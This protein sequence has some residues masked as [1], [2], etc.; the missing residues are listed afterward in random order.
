MYSTIYHLTLRGWPE[1]RQEVPHIARHFWGGREELSIDSSLLLK[2]IRVC[3]PLEL[4]NC[5][6]ADLYGAHQGTNRMQTQAREAVYWPGIDADIADYV[7]TKC[8]K[9]KASPPA[10]PMLPRDVPDGPWQEIV[11][12][13]FTHKGKEYLLICDL[14]SKYPFMYMVSTI[15]AQSLCAHLL[16]LVSQYGP[17]SLLFTDN[18]QPFASEE[19]TQFLQCHHTDHSTLSPHFPRSNGFID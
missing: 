12:D 7:C 16:D 8:T 17:P 15:S 10:Q 13:Y 14:F 11:A 18:G 1:Q 3:V 2:G 19:V 6:I 4:L 9:H 5:T